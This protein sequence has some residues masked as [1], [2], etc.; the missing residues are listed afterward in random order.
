MTTTPTPVSLKGSRVLVTG[1]AGFIGCNLVARLVQEGCRVRATIH[2]HPPV[3]T[4][5]AV[6]YVQADLMSQADCRRVVD[7]MDIVFHA[8]ATTLGAAVMA[9]APMILVTANIVITAQ[10]MEAAC[11][12]KVKRFLH[13]SSSVTYPDTGDQ[14]VRE[15][16]GLEGSPH[17]IYFGVGWAKRTAEVLAIFYSQKLKEPMPVTVVRP[18]NIFGP[19]DKFDPKASHVTAALIRRV[20]VRENP[21]VV[22]GTGN[23]VRDLLYID[24]FLDGVVLA[25]QHPDTYLAVNIASG[26][27][28]TVKEVIQMLLEL[29][30]F[31]DAKVQY[32]PTKP[33]M[34]PVRLID[35]TLAREKLGYRPHV[36][37]REGLRRTVQWYRDNRGKWDR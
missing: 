30:G 34:I 12:A 3:I 24:D 19:H 9:N 10:I 21:F 26:E 1:G 35:N 22:W 36:G 6:E 4:N 32:D 20:V 18:A 33:Q 13:L 14:P 25:V 2:K 23:D 37:L 5:P 31:T 15:E 16:Q 11:L 8:A 7:G 17:E 28:H 27:G 29:D